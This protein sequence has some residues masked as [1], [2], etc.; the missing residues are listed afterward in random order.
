MKKLF[1][2]VLATL[3]LGLAPVSAEVGDD[4]TFGVNA[5]VFGLLFGVLSGSLEMKLP[6]PQVTAKA[7]VTYSPN[8]FWVSGVSGLD[9]LATGRFYYG[10][11]LPFEMPEYLAFLKKGPLQGAYV[12]GGVSIHTWSWSYGSDSLTYFSPGIVLET[13]AKYFPETNWS[14]W[15]DN[16]YVE[17]GLVAQYNLPAEWKY[18]NGTKFSG[19][20]PS[21]F[22]P[23][24]IDINVGYAF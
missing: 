3:V 13:G 9:L 15:P 1:L 2:V 18:N 8:Y 21:F 16:F 20:E 23:L 4:K 17:P 12:G 14:W 6:V 11:L 10:K 5:D 7:D 19:S 24:S 22:N